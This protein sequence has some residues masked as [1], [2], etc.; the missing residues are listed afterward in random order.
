[1]FLKCLLLIL[2]YSY[3]TTWPTMPSVKWTKPH[4]IISHVTSQVE[5]DRKQREQQSRHKLQV[6]QKQRQEEERAR[7]HVEWMREQE[8]QARLQASKP[9]QTE[10]HHMVKNQVK[11][12]VQHGTPT[13]T[14][15]V[16]LLWWFSGC[17][18]S[19]YQLN[20]KS[21]G[22]IL[23]PWP[24]FS[25][26]LRNIVGFESVEMAISTNPKHTICFVSTPKT[27]IHCKYL[28]VYKFQRIYYLEFHRFETS[29]TLISC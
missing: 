16:W 6:E 27:S 24:V 12:P 5:N 25:Y 11:T 28:D 3:V 9:S 20:T 21:E 4:R 15:P 2:R 17:L 13:S 1:M 19:G 26:K 14:T 18:R 23:S 22:G 10:D 8:E 29:S 7:K